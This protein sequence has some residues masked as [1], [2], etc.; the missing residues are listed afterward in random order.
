[1]PPQKKSNRQGQFFAAALTGLL[2]S[3]STMPTDNE[4]REIIKRAWFI[5][6]EA[7]KDE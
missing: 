7:L 6:E 5:A 3:N 1:M 2:A 4:A